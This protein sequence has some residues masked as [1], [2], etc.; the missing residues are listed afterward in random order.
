MKI[1][2]LTSSF[3]SGLKDRDLRPDVAVHGAEQ[4]RVVRLQQGGGGAGAE[5]G[6]PVRLHD[7]EHCGGLCGGEAV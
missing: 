4:R 6:R 3:I 5:R 2:S 1:F 7:G